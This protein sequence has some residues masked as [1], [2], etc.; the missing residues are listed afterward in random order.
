MLKY[1]NAQTLIER[2]LTRGLNQS[3]IQRR[4]GISQSTISHLYK[5]T[6]GKRTSYEIVKKLEDLLLE[7]EEPVSV[8][9]A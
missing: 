3:E 5:G 1:M 8:S 7:V 6:R 2:L 4:T 9:S